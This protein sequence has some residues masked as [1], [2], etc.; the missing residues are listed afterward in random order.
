MFPAN[1]NNV[2]RL[3]RAIL[4]AI[5]ITLALVGPKTVWGWLGLIP[6]GTALLG[7]CPLYTVSA[8]TAG[9]AARRDGVACPMARRHSPRP[10][11]IS[12]RSE[13]TP[14]LSMPPWRGGES[15]RPKDRW[16]PRS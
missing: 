3:F 14:P 2:D 1:M 16:R 7:T 13:T 10:C 12:A 15:C 9:R 4:G 6:L 11:T 5:L 8:S